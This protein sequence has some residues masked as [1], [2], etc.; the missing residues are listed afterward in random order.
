MIFIYTKITE[1]S[2]ILNYG[3]NHI[4]LLNI[5]QTQSHGKY[6]SAQNTGTILV[7]KSLFVC[8]FELML[9]VTVNSNGHV[10]TLPPI[11]GTFTQH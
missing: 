9:Y 7:K 5:N 4:Y 8:L 2:K 11:Y 10:G 3:E 6:F 1:K